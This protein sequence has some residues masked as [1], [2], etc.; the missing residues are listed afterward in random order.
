METQKEH[1]DYINKTLMQR[2]KRICN[3]IQNLEQVRRALKTKAPFIVQILVDFLG[4]GGVQEWPADFLG[5]KF[6][7]LAKDT[8]RELQ[9][10]A[11][12]Y[13]V[14]SQEAREGGVSKKVRN[15]FTFLILMPSQSNSN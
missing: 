11:D 7:L 6:K 3:Q 10:R 4:G 14:K 2:K 12:I 1:K 5:S 8:W 9:P 15:I 13:H